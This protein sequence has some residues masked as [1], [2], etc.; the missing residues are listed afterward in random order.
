MWVGDSLFDGN[1]EGWHQTLHTL[2]AYS[3]SADY[4]GS[5]NVTITPI[6]GYRV[7]EESEPACQT[8]DASKDFDVNR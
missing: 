7:T 6:L 1:S 5:L 3:T 2:F 8:G 4:C